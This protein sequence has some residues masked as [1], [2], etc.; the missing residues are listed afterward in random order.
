[1]IDFT[2]STNP[3]RA[4]LA[5]LHNRPTA[6]ELVAT[7]GDR[8]VLVAYSQ[9][10]GRSALLKCLRHREQAVVSLFN[11]G[12]DPNVTFGKKASDGATVGAWTIR[13]S[14]RTQ[15][16]AIINGELPYVEDVVQKPEVA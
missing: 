4:K 2:G 15:R 10:Q 1:M 12:A 11:E 7:S 6:Y 16:D 14:G 8:S 3:I 9:S 5:R 13:F